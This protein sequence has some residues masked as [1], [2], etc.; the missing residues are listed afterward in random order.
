MW[1]SLTVLVAAAVLTAAAAFWALRAY[2]RAGGADAR[3]AFAVCGAAAVAALA[4]YLLLGR[5]DLADGPYR[6]RMEAL[7]ARVEAGATFDPTQFTPDEL[8]AVLHER[9]RGAPADPLPHF[10]TGDLLYRMDRPEEA[11]RAFDQALRRDPD[12][13]EAKLGLG[14]ALVAI[15][16]GR[17][18][19]EALALFQQAGPE[20]ENDPAPWM[21]QAMA[22]LQ[23]GEDARPFWREALAR[24]REGDPRRA[25]I[26][27]MLANPQP[28]VETP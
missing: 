15:D 5:A 25:M 18:S 12:M 21:Y 11:A 27:Q 28:D 1:I 4:C 20:L 2:R 26:S 7:A 8:L 17:V 22:A 24:A 14:R 23:A 19:P 16:G 10:F 3:A 6:A 13:A 9:A